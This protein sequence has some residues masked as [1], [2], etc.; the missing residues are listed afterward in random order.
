MRRFSPT[1]NHNIPCCP[2]TSAQVSI[3][4]NGLNATRTR[5]I[6]RI[7]ES[8][9]WERPAFQALIDTYL[10][11]VQA[12]PAPRIIMPVQGTHGLSLDELMKGGHA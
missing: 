12:A 9:A 7:V 3:V 5:T 6:Q 4:A 10:P 2:R 8:W 1:W 11:Q